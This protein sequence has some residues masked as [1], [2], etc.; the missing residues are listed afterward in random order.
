MSKS[1]WP[2]EDEI[3]NPEE[4]SPRF[5]LT[6]QAQYLEKEFSNIE[7]HVVYATEDKI[8]SYINT[9]EW[10]LLPSPE[11]SPLLK[12]PSNRNIYYR[13]IITSKSIDYIT[14][15]LRVKITGFE[16]YP[17]MLED[18]LTGTKYSIRNRNEFER[19]LAQIF[20]SKN[21]KQTLKNR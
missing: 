21:V 17:C 18:C 13:F 3:L 11:E 1:L 2:S 5:I 4:D 15:I 9:K 16:N 7:A 19:Y 10:T 12:V 20:N 14:E 6:E 8:K